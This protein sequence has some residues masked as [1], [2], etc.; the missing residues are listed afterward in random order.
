M[1]GAS[2]ISS[3]SIPTHGQYLGRGPRSEL[4]VEEQDCIPGMEA[5]EAAIPWDTFPAQTG[6]A[7]QHPLK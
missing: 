2:T 1:R 5:P 3:K 6:A 4:Q 7:E